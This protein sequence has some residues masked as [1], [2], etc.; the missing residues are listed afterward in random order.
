MLPWGGETPC[1]GADDLRE[2]LAILHAHPSLA[3]LVPKLPVSRKGFAAPEPHKL[4]HHRGPLVR[5]RPEAP[6]PAAPQPPPDLG[7][8]QG[9][10][11]DFLARGPEPSQPAFQGHR[12]GS[13]RCSEGLVSAPAPEAARGAATH[14]PPTGRRESPPLNWTP[15]RSIKGAGLASCT[16]PPPHPGHPEG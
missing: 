6:V 13:C 15:T 7:R 14:S 5:W 16:L 8:L 3:P 4:C 12:T 9:L 2:D 1:L 11:P 10:A